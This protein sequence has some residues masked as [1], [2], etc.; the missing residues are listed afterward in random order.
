MTELSTATPAQV[1]DLNVAAQQSGTPSP[2]DIPELLNKIF[3]FVNESTLAFSVPFVCRKWFLL[4]QRL[5]IR[6]AVIDTDMTDEELEGA[7]GRLRVARRMYWFTHFMSGD[8]ATR[9]LPQRERVATAIQK[10]HRR[11]EELRA[12]GQRDSNADDNDRIPDKGVRWSVRNAPLQE[13]IVVGKFMGFDIQLVH[14]LPFLSHLTVFRVETDFNCEVRLNAVFRACPLLQEV[15]IRP[16]QSAWNDDPFLDSDE[17]STSKF[18]AGEKGPLIHLQIFIIERCYFNTST[19]QDF[20]SAAPHL[21][22][23]QLIRIRAINSDDSSYDN[24]FDNDDTVEAA[25]N[26]LLDLI[27]FFER[28]TP[29]LPLNNFHL[30]AE[31]FSLETK[32][33]HLLLKLCPGLASSIS[34]DY[35]GFPD[36]SYNQLQQRLQLQMAPRNVIT[37]LDLRAAF[38][39]HPQH[40]DQLHY[41][42]CESPHLLHLYAP[43][44]C[45]RINHMDVYRRMWSTRLNEVTPIMGLARPQPGI[46]ACRKV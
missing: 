17:S 19:L 39:K 40:G 32:N 10:K 4:S 11:W 1:F 14:L 46:W 25:N 12:A 31:A 29:P 43:K 28:L 8:E 27:D 5:I 7:L 33:P 42:L 6:E 35:L 2:L 24:W 26:T 34:T 21:T 16:R 30:S 9:R 22:D 45:M 41:Y 44:I 15:T 37:V 38:G 13:L 23:L 3:S 36:R 20:I 18:T